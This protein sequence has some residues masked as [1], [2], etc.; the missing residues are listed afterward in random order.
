[1]THDVQKLSLSNKGLIG[2]FP[3]YLSDLANLN[4]LKIGGNFLGN[5]AD[6]ICT[7]SES[8]SLYLLG[9]DSNCPNTKLIRSGETSPGCCDV[10]HSKVYNHLSLFVDGYFGDKNC[11]NLQTTAETDA[12]SFMLDPSNQDRWEHSSIEPNNEEDSVW[13]NVSDTKLSEF[14]CNH[15]FLTQGGNI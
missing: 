7:R 13:L 12:C 1:M 4:T 8:G 10:V 2:A 14:I 11:N 3:D 5:V 9:D 15:L 6:A